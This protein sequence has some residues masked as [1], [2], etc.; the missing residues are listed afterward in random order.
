MFRPDLTFSQKHIW[1]KMTT[2]AFETKKKLSFTI[3]IRKRWLPVIT[4]TGLNEY[5]MN[6]RPR[7]TADSFIAVSSQ[8]MHERLSHI[9]M[10]QVQKSIQAGAVLGLQVADK[11][12][13]SASSSCAPCHLGKET[14]KPFPREDTTTRSQPMEIGDLSGKMRTLSLNGSRYFLQ[15]KDQATSFRGVYFLK[16]TDETE[17]CIQTFVELIETKS[18]NQVKCFNTISII[19]RPFYLHNSPKT[20]N[21]EINLFLTSDHS[22]LLKS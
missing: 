2:Q 20:S 7:K 9:N 13:I 10:Q 16:T 17:E 14:R 18:G 6:I 19:I 3:L 15:M 11:G 21:F 22:N 4:I 1:L 12:A 5:Q 8:L